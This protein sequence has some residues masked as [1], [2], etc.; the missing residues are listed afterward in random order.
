M[1]IRVALVDDYEVVVR[2]LDTM[3]RSY[4]DTIEVVELDAGTTVG[5]EVDI[6]MYDTFA[7]PRGDQEEVRI[8][9]ANPRVAKVVVYSWN[10]DADLVTAALSSGASGYLSKALP[11]KELVAA[12]VAVQSGAQVR[13]EP[14]EGRTSSVIGGDWPGREEGLSAREAEI[15]ALITQGLSNHEIADRVHLSINSVKTYIRS[16]YR[17]IGVSSRT[18]AVLWGLEHGFRP[19][20][21]KRPVR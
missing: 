16:C 19:N 9:I 10:L 17:R 11:A 8:L 5:Q 1:I 4:R 6:A 7:N 20:R 12:L 3:L 13:P 21:P 2:G 18:N 15:L 14:A